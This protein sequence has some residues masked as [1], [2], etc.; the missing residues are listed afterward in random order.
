MNND[1][2]AKSLILATEATARQGRNQKLF[3]AE[4]T[5]IPENG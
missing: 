2:L 3:T 4:D 5:E 1:E